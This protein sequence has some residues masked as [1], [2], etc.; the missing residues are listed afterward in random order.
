MRGLLLSAGEGKGEEEKGRGNSGRR[1][2]KGE[3]KGLVFPCDLFARA[4][5]PCFSRIILQYYYY[6]LP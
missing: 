1:G 3:G 5:R 4:R 2:R 6:I